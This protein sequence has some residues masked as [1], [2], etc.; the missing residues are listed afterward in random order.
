MDKEILGRPDRKYRDTNVLQP[1]DTAI[2]VFLGCILC[3]MQLH[4]N[5]NPTGELYRLS[6]WTCWSPEACRAL[7]GL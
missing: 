6:G 4:T 7:G 3:S 5:R 1:G 2:T